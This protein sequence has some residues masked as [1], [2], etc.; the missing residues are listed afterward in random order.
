MASSIDGPSEIQTGTGSKSITLNRCYYDILVLHRTPEDGTFQFNENSVCQHPGECEV[1]TTITTR[2]EEGGGGGGSSDTG[3]D[4]SLDSDLG[5]F[6]GGGGGEGTT[7]EPTE[8]SSVIQTPIGPEDIAV[9]EYSLA[10]KV[11]ALMEEDLTYEQYHY[12]NTHAV[13]AKEILDFLNANMP[14]GTLPADQAQ[15]FAKQVID[16]LILEGN[17][18]TVSPYL[19]YPNEF[20]E[21]YRETYPRFTKFIE[22]E[23]SN[24]SENAKIVNAIQE[25]T[26]L[27]ISVIKENL[28]WN[29][30]GPEIHIVQLDNYDP[31]ITNSL[32]AGAYDP[33][34]PNLRRIIYLDIDTVLN[35]ET[36][37]SPNDDKSAYSFFIST[38]ILHEFVHWGENINPSFEYSGE[39]GLDFE[40]KVFGDNVTATNARLIF[41]SFNK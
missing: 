19:K 8:P 15:D 1:I 27:G 24:L 39:E 25:F 16:D 41:D 13:E 7:G 6:G 12:L 23:F 40:I 37:S 2:C 26:G 29:D 38:V 9:I 4:G 34:D 20:A 3:T 18:T 17:L 30:K 11:Y 21:Y 33:R 5:F 14:N 36:N 10:F 31:G 32:T 28:K 22:Q 35:F